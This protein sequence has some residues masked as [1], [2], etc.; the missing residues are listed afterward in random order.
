[1]SKQAFENRQHILVG[2]NLAD[3]K[4]IKDKDYLFIFF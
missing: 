1:M 2:K 4:E 3:L